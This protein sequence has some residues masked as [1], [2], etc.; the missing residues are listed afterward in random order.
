VCSSDLARTGEGME[1][2]HEWLA[3]NLHSYAR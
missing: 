2:W 1:A 3:Q